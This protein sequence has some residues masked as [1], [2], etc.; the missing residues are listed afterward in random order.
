[1]TRPIVYRPI[2]QRAAPAAQLLVRP[3]GDLTTAAIQRLAL[4]TD[5]EILLGSAQPLSHVIEEY[6]RYPQFRARLLFFFAG[7][8]LFLATVGLYGAGASGGTAYA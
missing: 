8:A 2:T 4:E 3:R 5:D 1:M 7:I 6:F